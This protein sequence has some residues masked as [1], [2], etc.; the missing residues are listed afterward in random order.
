MVQLSEG[1]VIEEEEMK[2]IGI[3]AETGEKGGDRR[4]EPSFFPIL[5]SFF[6][7]LIFFFFFFFF[8]FFLLPIFFFFFCISLPFSLLLSSFLFSFFFS[9]PSS[10]EI[11]EGTWYRKWHGGLAWRFAGMP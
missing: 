2:N 6:I 9:S 5:P 11:R 3:Q 7:F 4:Q 8:P 1:M 10:A